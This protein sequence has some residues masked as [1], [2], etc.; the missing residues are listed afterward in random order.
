M[1]LMILVG[2]GWLFVTL[3]MAVVEATSTTGT[4]LGAIVTFVFYGL[5]PL[6]VVLYLL[7]TPARRRAQRAAWLAALPSQAAA[8]TAPASV[9]TSAA[10]SA[11]ASTTV[12]LA[13]S[14]LGQ[15]TPDGGGHAPGDAV[16]P[17]REKP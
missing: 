6:A 13:T 2:I 1:Y 10:E 15:L 12:S 16:A 11:A 7:N 17:E 8:P 5:L 4:V 14:A 9:T 3:L